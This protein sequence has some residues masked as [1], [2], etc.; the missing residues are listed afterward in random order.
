MEDSLLAT[1][2]PSSSISVGAAM[3]ISTGMVEMENVYACNY[4]RRL[5]KEKKHLE[6]SSG[7]EFKNTAHSHPQ[8][9]T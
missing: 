5:H 9:I 4:I 6:S 2:R 1:Y 7:E 3:V 8:G